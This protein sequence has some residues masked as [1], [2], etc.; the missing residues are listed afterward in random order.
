MI[1][2]I[3]DNLMAVEN[4]AI[5]SAIKSLSSKFLTPKTSSFHKNTYMSKRK[6]FSVAEATI[7]LLIGSVALGMA[8]PMIT[9]Q[10]KTQNMTDTQF[11]VMNNRNQALLERINELEERIEE[12]ENVENNG[13]PAGTIAFF[14]ATT[15]PDGWSVVNAKYNGRFPRFAGNY[16]ICDKDGENPDGTCKSAVSSSVVNNAVNLMSGDAI[17]NISASILRCSGA[18]CQLFGEYAGV[19][20][21]FSATRT[22]SGAFPA[23]DHDD[24]YYDLIHKLT[25]NA[26]LVVPTS[27]ENRPKSI[28]LLGCKKNLTNKKPI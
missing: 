3:A 25:F 4:G 5:V 22:T 10:I 19:D 12:L 13:V 17:R 1:N 16:D 24:Y 8:A 15:C 23:A 18:R 11:R 27:I 20:G 7:A 14:E 9:K 21:A 28:T 2:K 26:S 6:A